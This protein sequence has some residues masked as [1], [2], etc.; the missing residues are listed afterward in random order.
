[1]IK[2]VILANDLLNGDVIFLSRDLTTWTKFLDEAWTSGSEQLVEQMLE[3]AQQS[4]LIIGAEAVEVEQD[5]DGL[6][7]TVF[8]EHLRSLGPS[9]RTD[10]GKQALHRQAA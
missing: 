5:Q 7:L 10:L 2:K 8:R 1:M 9:V 3:S 4:H 6:N